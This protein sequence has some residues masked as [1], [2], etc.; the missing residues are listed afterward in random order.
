MVCMSKSLDPNRNQKHKLKYKDNR[1]Y[2][3]QAS[4]SEDMGILKAYS[5]KECHSKCIRENIEPDMDKHICLIESSRLEEVCR[6]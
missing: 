2:Q 5:Y 4:R 3:F 1:T 6:E